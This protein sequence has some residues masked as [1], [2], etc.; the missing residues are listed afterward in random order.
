MVLGARR[1]GVAAALSLAALASPLNA[2]TADAGGARSAAA[3]TRAQG[4]A[5][6][7]AERLRRQAEAARTEISQLN[8]RLAATSARDKAA[9]E[10]AGEAAQRYAETTRRA[11]ALAETYRANRLAYENAVISAAFAA[12]G[13]QDPDTA[14]AGV[15]AAAA[16]A[17]F[18]ARLVRNAAD[19]AATRELAA[20]IGA[21]QGLIADARADIAAERGAVQL[22]I[23]DRRAVQ[24]T[25]SRNAE[26]AERR[27]QQLA[28]EAHSLQELAQ[29]SATAR[30]P[31][32][33]RGAAV[34][35]ASW[36]A[37]ASGQII[38]RFGERAAGG[39]P[40]AG[41]TLRTASGARVVAP[42]AGEVAYAR[43]FRSYGNVLILN[44]EG[45]YALIV[46]GLDTVNAR[47]GETVSAGQLLGLMSASAA[48]APDLYVEVRRDGRS[49]DPARLLAAGGLVAQ[50]GGQPG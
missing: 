4:V 6:A 38:R 27:A 10:A 30:R 45:G 43:L 33:G 20:G 14:R 1:A 25:L 49:I 31:R 39:P 3:V 29:R 41:A 2:A 8:N 46:T 44:L 16:A 11:E 36:I 5:A 12:R 9:N 7:E 40:A 24:T 21:E 34:L 35:P 37:P 48:P 13:F 50:A 42:A 47:E 19:L 32:A 17:E 15:F 18:Q 26:A 28:R 22:L 23:A